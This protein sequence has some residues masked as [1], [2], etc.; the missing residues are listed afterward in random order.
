MRARRVRVLARSRR[1]WDS[2][3]SPIASLWRILLHAIRSLWAGT[4]AAAGD[5]LF[6]TVSSGTGSGS[7]RPV[8]AAAR[9][10]PPGAHDQT[11]RD[12]RNRALQWVHPDED[13]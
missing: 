3:L 7:G 13:R 4:N 6:D 1:Y 5:A 12:A 2:S 10:A 11:D 8:E 9:Y